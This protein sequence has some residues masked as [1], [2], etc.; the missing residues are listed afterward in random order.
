MSEHN[1]NIIEMSKI[2]LDFDN[3]LD[4]G[5]KPSWIFLFWMT[6]LLCSL[7]KRCNIICILCLNLHRYMLLTCLTS[8]LDL[9]LVDQFYT[10]YAVK[11][12]YKYF[13]QRVFYNLILISNDNQ[14]S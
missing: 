9:V 2:Q 1:I 11:E 5:S 12:A 10:S 7:C 8:E 13:N 14:N 6:N 4:N 3:F